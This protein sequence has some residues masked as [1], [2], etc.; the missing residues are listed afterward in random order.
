VDFTTLI[1]IIACA[2]LITL[3][4]AS[5]DGAILFISIPSL[6]I[7]VGGTVGATLVTYPANLLLQVVKVASKAFLGK[8]PDVGQ[9]IT[10]FGTLSRK[11]RREGLL[12]LQSHEEDLDDEFYRKG[13]RLVVDGREAETVHA[14]LSTE[15][16]SI[17]QRHATGA[18]IFERM[19]MYAPAFGMIGTVI[20]LIQMLQSMEDPSTIGPAMAVALITTLY[21]A[22]LANVVF[23]PVAGKLRNRSRE[24][25]HHKEMLLEGFLSLLSGDDPHVIKEKLHSL[26]RPSERPAEDK[27]A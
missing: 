2:V 13:L 18:Q 3:T 10:L 16:D 14:I 21:G 11:A 27:A 23:I 12:S 1:G 4:I 9:V 25:V 26:V 7:V 20:G 17:I 5:R 24:E 15:V 8:T 6:L 22:L 19:G